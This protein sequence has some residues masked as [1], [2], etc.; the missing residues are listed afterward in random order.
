MKYLDDRFSVYQ[1][2]SPNH[3]RIFRDCFFMVR[4]IKAKRLLRDE[5]WCGKLGAYVPAD[6]SRCRECEHFWVRGT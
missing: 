5:A 4:R 2:G 1:S 6:K 3:D